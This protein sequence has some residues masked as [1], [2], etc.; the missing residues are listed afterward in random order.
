MRETDELAKEL[1]VR[2]GMPSDLHVPIAARNIDAIIRYIGSATKISSSAFIVAPYEVPPRNPK[3]R[4]W[5]IQE[6]DIFHHPR[7]VWVHVNYTSYRKAYSFAFPDQDLKN[8]VVDHIMNRRLARLKGFEYVRVVP[9][10]RS[11]N[12]SSGNITEK[13]G[14]AY[15]STPGIKQHNAL[16]QPSIQYCDS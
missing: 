10:S 3:L 4:I 11:A 14:V 9:I 16:N 2:W 6:A 15:H 7:Q 5:K 13:Y 1:A 12:S 8:L